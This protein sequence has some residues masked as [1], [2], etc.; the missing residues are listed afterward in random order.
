MAEGRRADLVLEVGGVRGLGAAGAAI[1]CWRR[2][3][4]LYLIRSRAV[5]CPACLCS[6]GLYPCSEGGAHTRASA[7]DSGC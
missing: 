4:R 7:S 6:A 1:G 5:C 3:C 2:L